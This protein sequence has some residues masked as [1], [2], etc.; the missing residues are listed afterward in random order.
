M[1]FHIVEI[2]TMTSP[3]KASRLWPQQLGRPLRF[4]PLLN[5]TESHC[6]AENMVADSTT[7]PVHASRYY[8]KGS[9]GR[10]HLVGDF[11]NA[12]LSCGVSRS[13]GLL[14]RIAADGKCPSGL[15][16]RKEGAC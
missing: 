7:S 1:R 13:R 14:R 4:R 8:E 3:K 6:P 2:T 16:P 11:V 9:L 12:C 5:I 15:R 10:M